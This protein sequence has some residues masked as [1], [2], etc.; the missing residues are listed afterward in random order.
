MA[1][2]L[3]LSPR[4]VEKHINAIF[5]KLG[6]AGDLSVDHRVKAVL[7]FLSEQKSSGRPGRQP[8]LQARVCAPG[9][10]L[11]AD[12]T[13]PVVPGQSVPLMVV[14]AQ[15]SGTQAAGPP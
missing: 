8:S 12:G 2:T 6:L 14:D 9:L 11:L 15:V 13:V 1:A 4:A 5:A 7:L 10:G 3:V